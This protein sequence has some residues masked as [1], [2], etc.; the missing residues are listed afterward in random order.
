MD[1]EQCLQK[2]VAPGTRRKGK[3]LEGVIQIWTTNV[4]NASCYNCTQSGNLI[5][6]PRFITPEQFAMA[7]ESLRGFYGVVGMF[8]SNCAT[9]P[10]FAELCKILRDSWVPIRQRGIW[11][12]DP[13]TPDK[14][15]EMRRTFSPQHSNLNVH[16]SQKAYDM[17]K[18]YWPECNPVGLHQ[19]SRHSPVH[20]AMKDIIS[21]E[22]RRWELISNCDINANWSAGVGVFRDQLRAYFCE[23]A[24]SQ[25]ILYQDDPDYPDTGLDPTLMYA[26][27]T[28]RVAW[29]QLPMTSFAHQVM[30]HCHDCGVPL[31]GYGELANAPDDKGVEQT[32][33]THANIYKPKRKGR[34]VELVTVEAQLGQRLE[35][36]T[37]YI[38]NSEK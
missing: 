3:Y 29:W 21:D 36:M 15:T 13:I 34:R 10:K 24:M 37:K 9:H 1:M 14:A 22:S 23:V 7:I 4:C 27:V 25:S 12:N 30:K 17:F 6:T 26:T 28:R 33:Q 5:Q 35:R 11:S 20:L 32:S 2:M 31:R 38:Q 16:Q 19:D 18:K 8:G